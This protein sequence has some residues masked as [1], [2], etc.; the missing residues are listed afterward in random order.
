CPL[1]VLDNLW[2]VWMERVARGPYVTTISLFGNAIFLLALLIGVNSLVRRRAP[3][4]AMS[5]AELLL[6]YSMVAIGAAFAGLDMVSILIQMI[7]HPI[8]FTKS[9]GLEKYA[10]YLP[11]PAMVTDRTALIGFF[12]GSDTFY[13]QRYFDA[14]LRP[15]LIWIGFVTLLVYVMQ[16]VNVLVRKQWSD[17]ERLTYRI[18]ILPLEITSAATGLG[19]SRLL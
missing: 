7:T 19:R 16:C 2:V 10:R 1:I 5:Q 13:R 9:P 17:R 3:Q 11:R 8:W 4:L 14:W 12:N 6:I 18:T 15:S